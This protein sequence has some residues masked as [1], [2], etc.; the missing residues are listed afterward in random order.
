MLV[1]KQEVGDSLWLYTYSKQQKQTTIDS[2]FC[3]VTIYS[4]LQLNFVN[5]T[6]LV[7][8]NKTTLNFL[9]RPKKKKL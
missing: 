4:I 7:Y 9:Q 3:T 6:S 2:S 8:C 1:I 5:C